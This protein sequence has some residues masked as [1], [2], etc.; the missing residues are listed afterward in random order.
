MTA[1]AQ[2]DDIKAKLQ[3]LKADGFKRARALS[4]LGQEV[5]DGKRVCRIARTI[6]SLVNTENA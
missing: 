1:S 6:F 2:A 3:F 5:I 4:R